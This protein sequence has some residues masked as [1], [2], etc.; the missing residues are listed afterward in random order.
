MMSIGKYNNNG[1]STQTSIVNEISARSGKYE[2]Q[3][4][5]NLK[6]SLVVGHSCTPLNNSRFATRRVQTRQRTSSFKLGNRKFPLQ[7][8]S[9]FLQLPLDI[10][11]NITA[12]IIILY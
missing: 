8:R 10:G 9:P 1:D 7:L 12:N 11:M 6:E 3:T 5:I 2:G 4:K